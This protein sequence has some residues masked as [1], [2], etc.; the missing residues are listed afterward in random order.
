LVVTASNKYI[1]VEEDAGG[2]EI[3]SITEKVYKDPVQLATALQDALNNH[4]GLAAT[5]VVSY[6][7]TTGKFTITAS[8]GPTTITIGWKTGAVHGADNADTHIGT[9][10]GFSDTADDSGA[11]TYTSDNAIT[12]T[13]PYTPTFDDVDMIVAKNLTCLL[14]D[15]TDT[16]CFSAASVNFTLNNARGVNDSICTESG[17]DGSVITGRTCEIAVVANLSQYEA[18]NFSRFRLGDELGFMVNF[19]NKS[20]NNWVKTKAGCLSALS[21]TISAFSLSDNNGLMQLNMTLSPFVNS[22]SQDEVAL[23]FV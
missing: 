10:L 9:L 2:E 7:S 6:S 11:L 12:L 22:T 3:V 1:E 15:A 8:G 19:G 17:R 20:A 18:K 21:A 4:S 5:Y 14:G 16:T 13:S 23:S